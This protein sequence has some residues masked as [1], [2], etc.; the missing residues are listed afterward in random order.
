MTFSR[1]FLEKGQQ[2]QGNPGRNVGTK[3]TRL[4]VLREKIKINNRSDVNL[5]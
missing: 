4:L 5:P 2:L 1:N 3:K